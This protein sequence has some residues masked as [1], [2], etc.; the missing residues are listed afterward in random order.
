MARGWVIQILMSCCHRESMDRISGCQEV[1][2]GGL[3]VD[4]DLVAWA[5]LEVDLAVLVEGEV[6]AAVLV[7]GSSCEQRSTRLIC[8]VMIY[9]TA[10]YGFRNCTILYRQDQP[11]A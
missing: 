7:A 9:F 4:L 8:V 6:V 2:G 3:L 11:T 1:V 10:S 5:D